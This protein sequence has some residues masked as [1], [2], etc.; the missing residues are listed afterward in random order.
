[1]QVRTTDGNQV[2][3]GAQAK[4]GGWSGSSVFTISRVGRRLHQAHAVIGGIH[5]I[6]QGHL[7]EIAQT[8]GLL[9]LAL[10]AGQNAN[11]GDDHQQFNQRESL[12]DHG[13]PFHTSLD[14]LENGKSERPLTKA[15]PRRRTCQ[16]RQRN[17][18]ARVGQGIGLGDWLSIVIIWH[19]HQ[20]PIGDEQSMG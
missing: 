8:P 6:D 12:R 15:G 13:I 1:M 7:L 16:P 20:Y 5:D 18:L 3:Y 9:C 2:N 10:C 19:P 14:N 17:P 11:H 4:A